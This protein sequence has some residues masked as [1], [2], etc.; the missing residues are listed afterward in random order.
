ME[1][2]YPTKYYLKKIILFN[3]LSF[4][5]IYLILKFGIIFAVKISDIFQKDKKVTENEASDVFLAS[6]RFNQQINATNSAEISISGYSLPN[7]DVEI[8][9]NGTQTKTIPTNSEG[10]FETK[11]ILSSG[12]NLISSSTKDKN[13]RL[14]SLSE[15]M[16]IYY[17]DT[18]P[19]IEI[20]EPKNE[21]LIRGDNNVSIKGSTD[22]I[23][24]V[25]INDHLIIL[26]KDGNFSYQVKLNS[27][28]N[29]FKIVCF[30]PAQ[31]K[32]EKEIKI[33]YQR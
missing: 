29:I 12:T 20:T 8:Y 9:L 16:N 30:D 21:D 6:P 23:N 33:R 32:T 1:E 22:K 27:G 18:N 2:E 13:G 17:S 25:H 3:L 31:N 19:T 26:D 10:K 28:E 14:S 15:E 7:Q 5:L 24:K 4:C 11:I